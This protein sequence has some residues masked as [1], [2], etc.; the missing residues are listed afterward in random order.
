MQVSGHQIQ[1]Q[2]GRNCTNQLRRLY[3]LEVVRGAKRAMGE[4]AVE[5]CRRAGLYVQ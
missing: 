5:Y 1:L 2:V 4:A 3:W